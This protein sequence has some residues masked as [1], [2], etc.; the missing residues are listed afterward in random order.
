M[1]RLVISI[2]LIFSAAFAMFLPTWLADDKKIIVSDKDAAL[3][4]NY[5]A[6]NLRSKLF[7]KD[8]NLV[9]QVSA[10]KMEHFDMLGFVNF[11]QPEYT[12]YLQEDGSRWQLNADEGTFYDSNKIEL[13]SGVQIRNLQPE[14]YIQTIST[15]FIEIDLLT[16]TITSDEPLVISGENFMINGIG[17]EA[18][19]E[20]QKYEL[21]KHVQTEYLPVR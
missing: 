17:F 3:F 1:N 6:K 9:H 4:P 20:T 13:V 16:K 7:N 14:D 10:E 5:E 18:N 2:V 19:L 8:G 15:D 12:I 11:A 21:K